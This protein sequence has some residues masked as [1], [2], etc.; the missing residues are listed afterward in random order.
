[1][2][3]KNLDSMVVVMI[4]FMDSA[5]GSKPFDFVALILSTYKQAI[6]L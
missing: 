5:T 4:P 6:R 1:M 2:H 3:K